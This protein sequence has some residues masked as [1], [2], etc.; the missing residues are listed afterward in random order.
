MEEWL[1]EAGRWVV[2]LE[3]TGELVRALPCNL[4]GLKA[5][6]AEEVDEETVA[7]KQHHDRP[8]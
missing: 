4:L 3:G 8:I 1:E 5:V 7:S 6:A 2:R